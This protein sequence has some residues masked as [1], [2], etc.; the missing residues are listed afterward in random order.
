MPD[1]DNDL[2]AF[3]LK[4]RRGGLLGMSAFERMIL[5]ILLFMLVT[6]LGLLLL[7]MTNRIVF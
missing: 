3:A 7:I 4:R 2:A 5:S 6:V 1:A